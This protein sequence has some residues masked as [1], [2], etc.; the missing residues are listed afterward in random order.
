MLITALLNPIKRGFLLVSFVSIGASLCCCNN[1]AKTSSNSNNYQDANIQQDSSSI[2]KS[3]LD[4]VININD[5]MYEAFPLSKGIDWNLKT[6]VPYPCDSFFEARGIYYDNDYECWR[7]SGQI[8]MEP[9]QETQET[10]LNES[11]NNKEKASQNH[12]EV[13]VLVK[14]TEK[15]EK[16]ARVEESMPTVNQKAL[17]KG[18]EKS[19]SDNSEIIAKEQ[20]CQ[21]EPSGL[22]QY[23]GQGGSGGTGY[24]LGERKAINLSRPNFDDFEDGVVVVNIWVNC[25]GK[26]I[27]AEVAKGTTVTNRNIRQKAI[28]AALQSSFAADPNADEEQKGTITYTFI[29]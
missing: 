29:N 14:P 22:K 10:I 13:P 26:V 20:G 7:I 17:F 24:N 16:E 5:L 27:R 12:E 9:E 19:F 21:G 18:G 28:D 6:K 8:F 11:Q 23:A 15:T 25:E 1:N 3:A 4:Q 2:R